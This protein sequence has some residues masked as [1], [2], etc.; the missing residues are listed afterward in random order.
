[1][2]N[3]KKYT[4]NDQ[5][6]IN[7]SCQSGI[8]LVDSKY[9]ASISTN[10]PSDIKVMHYAGEKPWNNVISGL[11]QE[12]E[13]HY[14]QLGLPMIPNKIH[15]CWFGGNKKPA[16][17]EK[18]I[19]SWKK[20][21]PDCTIVEWNE[22]SIDI[23][24]NAFIKEAYE[25]KKYAFVTDYVRLYALYTQG[26]V[27]MDG[28]VELLKPI[29]K[30]L[31]HRA[32]TGY[33]TEDIPITAIMGAEP[34]HPWVKTLLSY[35]DKAKFTTVPNTQ[36]IPGQ[37]RHMFIESKNG[38]GLYQNDL[39]VYPV[40]TFCSYDHNNLKITPTENSYAVHHFAGTWLERTKV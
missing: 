27:Y 39:H 24:S 26:G 18:C 40:E 17:I 13:L 4:F 34:E 31:Q 19:A 22:S 1:M 10:I 36:I 35:Y 21:A 7:L 2:A 9:N 8:T 12:N 25:Q 38:I 5:D 30:F 3:S 6:I 14:R 11:W 15:Y 20:Y 37:M 32:F 23:N 16:I 29:D 33:E 28:D